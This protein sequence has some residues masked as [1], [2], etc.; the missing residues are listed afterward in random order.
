[1]SSLRFGPVF[2]AWG[3]ELQVKMELGTTE[4]LWIF[5]ERPCTAELVSE[6][7]WW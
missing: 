4:Q 1:M 7:I 3:Y 2:G 6:G 5:Q